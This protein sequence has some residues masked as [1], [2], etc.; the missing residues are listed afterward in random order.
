MSTCI[1]GFIQMTLSTRFCRVACVHAKIFT[2][3]LP[4]PLALQDMRAM[5]QSATLKKNMNPWIEC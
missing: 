3:L 2:E 4:L 1:S 5:P